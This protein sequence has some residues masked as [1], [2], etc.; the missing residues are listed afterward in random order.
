V[1]GD[2][3]ER[4]KVLVRAT[5]NG[6]CVDE[7][8]VPRYYYRAGDIGVLSWKDAEINLWEPYVVWDDDPDKRPRPMYADNLEVIGIQSGYNRYIP[9]QNS[10]TNLLQQR[11]A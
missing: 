6:P 4:V 9:P 1:F 2:D 8:G 3:N 11:R 10:S 5:D 7:E